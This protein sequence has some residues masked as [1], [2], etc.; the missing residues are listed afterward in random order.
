MPSTPPERH[1][2]PSVP[3]RT[4]DT[5]SRAELFAMAN[6]LGYENTILMSREELIRLLSARTPA[7]GIASPRVSDRALLRYA[8]AY[9]AACR[10]RD[11]HPIRAVTA[12]VSPT[13]DDP[14]AYSYR[15][16][17]EARRRDL[18]TCP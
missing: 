8:A 11:S 16:V 9:A 15:M 5:L 12:L 4:L 3:P 18:L 13:T 7:T 14:I 10:E 1:P 17:A 6:D 2:G